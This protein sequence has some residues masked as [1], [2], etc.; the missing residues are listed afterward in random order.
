MIFITIITNFLVL[1][2][3]KEATLPNLPVPDLEST[4]QKYLTQVEVIAPNHLPKTR[5]LVKAFLSGPG[6][7]LQ[8]RLLERRQKVSNWVSEFYHFSYLTMAQNSY[9]YCNCSFFVATY[10]EYSW[11]LKLTYEAKIPSKTNIKY[12]KQRRTFRTRTYS[13]YML[14]YSKQLFLALLFRTQYSY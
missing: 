2:L 8:Q 3:Q 7:K 12:L 13:R 1:T 9:Y 10:I 4:L 14:H 5:N 11:I 6:P